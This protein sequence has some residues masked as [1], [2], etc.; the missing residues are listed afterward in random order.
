MSSDAHSGVRHFVTNM[1]SSK[2]RLFCFK[3]DLF[4]GRGEKAS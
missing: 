4:L 1:I 2:V 3:A